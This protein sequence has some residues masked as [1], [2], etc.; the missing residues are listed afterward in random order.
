MENIFFWTSIHCLSFFN[1]RLPILSCPTRYWD[2]CVYN[3]IIIHQPHYMINN[4][5]WYW[6]FIDMTLQ[7]PCLLVVTNLC[8]FLARD[9]LQS[10]L[11]AQ[12]W[13][14]F[15][16]ILNAMRGLSF[17]VLQLCSEKFFPRFHGFPLSPLKIITAWCLNLCP[18][19]HFISIFR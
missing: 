17:L 19:G 3:N 7:F 10:W 16:S 18:P 6:F 11:L 4:N 1:G 9:N 5:Y 15:D 8:R 2:W 12:M 13:S 14:E